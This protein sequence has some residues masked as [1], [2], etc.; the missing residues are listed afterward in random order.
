MAHPAEFQAVMD[1]LVHTGYSFAGSN[2]V[3]STVDHEFGHLVDAWITASH[4]G[5]DAAQEARRAFFFGHV[6]ARTNRGL[7]RYSEESAAESFAEA[8]A[9]ARSGNAATR[10]HPYA[11][12][13][14]DWVR[15]EAA[16]I[17]AA[18]HRSI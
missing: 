2:T 7:S 1:H 3:S 11:V 5:H 9:A 8:F 18:S 12:A 13:I 4:H 6:M 15:Q 16:R 14:R 17:R 10:A